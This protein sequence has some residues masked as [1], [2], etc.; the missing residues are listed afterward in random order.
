V[1]D[2]HLEFLVRLSAN[3]RTATAVPSPM[4]QKNDHSLSNAALQMRRPEY[5]P[6]LRE[7]SQGSQPARAPPDMTNNVHRRFGPVCHMHNLHAEG[8]HRC[9]TPSR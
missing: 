7:N 9:C 6:G 5:S 4:R 8:E 2:R 3:R 1:R